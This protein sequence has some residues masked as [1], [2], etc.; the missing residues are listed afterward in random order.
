MMERRDNDMTTKS[1]LEVALSY[2]ARGWGVFPLRGKAP[3]I[4]KESGGSGYLDA[5]TNET[6]IRAWWSQYPTA[7]I[8]IATQASGLL[9]LDVDERHGGNDTLATLETRHRELP[10]TPES[11]TGGGGR[12]I[13]FRAPRPDLVRRKA[14]ALGDGLDLP[15]YIVAPPSVHPE[16]GKAY[17][18]NGAFLPDDIAMADTPTWLIDLATSSLSRNP[19]IVDAESR[20]SEGNRNATLT[21]LAGTMRRRGMTEEALLA[22]LL[23][24]NEQRCDPPLEE[25][26]ITLIAASIARYEPVEVGTTSG[27]GYKDDD[28]S[29]A[30]GRRLVR[31]SDVASE[32]VHWLWRG[33]I[34][35]GKVT[36]IAGDPGLG[37]SWAT[38]DLAARVSVGGETPDRT[39]RMEKGAVVLLTAE[40]GL[41]DT[42]RPRVDA[43][44]G[45][46]SQVHVL[47]AIVG[48]DG[49]EH[50]PSLTEDIAK[51][52]EVVIS[53]GASLVI[54]D[55]LNAFMGRTDTH[56]DSHVRRALTPLAKM[57][58]RTGV[59][60]VVVMHLNQ[61]TPQSPIYRVQGS[62]GFVGLARSVLLVVKN[63]D[64]PGQR[65][66]V[67]IKAN[68][69]GEMPAIG[70]AITQEPA[71]AWQGVVEGIDVASLLAPKSLDRES[72]SKLGEAKDFLRQVLMYGP[73][74]AEDVK[75]EAEEADIETR[76]LRR[77]RESL[78][79]KA[80]RY[81]EGSQRGE[82]Y[83]TWE[84]VQDGQEPSLGDGH[85]ESQT[86]IDSHDV[87][88]GQR[89]D[90]QDDHDEHAGDGQEE[91]RR[92]FVL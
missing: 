55:P 22:A 23:V 77:A 91:H 39:Q 27:D 7:N 40:D 16:T 33:Y 75:H 48:A 31:L 43:Q 29:G 82:G 60:I 35:Y 30:T 49:E 17:A 78:P 41:A 50:I 26:E 19:Q 62:I 15:N 4:P 84:L 13:Y 64:N 68:L 71:L 58:E 34:P 45:D 79:I 63:E 2:A 92:K 76:T 67:P 8:G 10:D 53:T 61:S 89:L 20:I 87:P 51:L 3:A 24:E 86:W 12:H 36:L 14:A 69:V 18:W 59:A 21:S 65:I 46:A 47:D 70:F 32:E 52:E 90:D 9:V 73:E 42:V 38:L 74:K 81:S 5:T 54:I 28:S 72:S 37:K 80:V 66:L 57:A 11:I 1:M 25:R 85:V 44:G 88:K 56:V 6:Q 83:W